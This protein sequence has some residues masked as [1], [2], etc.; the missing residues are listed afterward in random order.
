MAIS[1]REIV[2]SVKG[3]SGRPEYYSGRGA[4][5]SDLDGDRLYAIYQKIEQELGTR[6]ADAFVTMVE[7]LKT[8]SATNFLNALYALERNDWNLTEFNESNIDLGSDG[9]ERGIIAFATIAEGLFGCGRDDTEYIRSSFLR[10][11]G[12]PE[13]GSR[14]RKREYCGDDRER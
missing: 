2:Y 1:A 3:M 8:L 10:K 14:E 5:M 11:L 7:K 9:A 13:R 12:F 4:T 6:Q